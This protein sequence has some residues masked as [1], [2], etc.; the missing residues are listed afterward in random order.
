[1]KNSFFVLLKISL[2]ILVAS[3]DRSPQQA[4]QS[5]EDTPEVEQSQ[6]QTEVTAVL[7]SFIDASIAR[8]YKIYYE[9]LSEQDRAAKSREIFLQEKQ[10]G[11]VTLADAFYDKI[12]YRIETVEVVNDQ[13]RASV[14]YNFPDVEFMIKDKFGLS[15]LSDFT[16]AEISKMKSQ[17]HA[18]ARIVD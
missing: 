14:E 18:I 17:L 15:I 3:C 9:F 10:A 12:T 7:E 6:A 5:S 2:L 4:L 11:G 13:A 8:Q 1:M 16:E